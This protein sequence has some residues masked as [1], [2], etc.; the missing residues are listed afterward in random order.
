MHIV[1]QLLSP[2]TFLAALGCGLV[3]G[4]FFAFSNFVMKALAQVPAEH[5]MRA[6]QAINVTVL[7]PLFLTLFLGTAGLCV[8]LGIVSV[9]RWHSPGAL[10]LLAGSALYF[11]G[12]FVVTTA[13]NVP[14]NDAL[15]RLNPSAPEAADAW[16]KYVVEWTR[17]NHVRTITA[18]AGAA[19]FTIAFCRMRGA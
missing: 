1:D 18:L 19:A 11:F 5:G 12:N 8:L 6:M 9:V 7:N 10:G 15:A 4:I 16:R 13:C 2:L 14:R 17:W 3:S